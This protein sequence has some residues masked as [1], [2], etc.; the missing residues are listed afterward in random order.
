MSS[1][2]DRRTN[3]E[4][5]V[6]RGREELMYEGHPETQTKATMEQETMSTPASGHLQVA[7]T[8]VLV[9]C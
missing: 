8:S 2:K 7:R 1:D 6:R 5:M 9:A 3:E 4:E